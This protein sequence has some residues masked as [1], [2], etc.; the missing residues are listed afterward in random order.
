[1]P[2][3]LFVQDKVE[4]PEP[5]VI[6][7][8]VMEHDG[9]VEFA[10]TE[11]VTVPKNPFRGLIIIVDVPGTLTATETVEGFTEMVKSG[12]TVTW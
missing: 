3:T 4:F 12:G 8:G 10:M 1:M 2:A 9:L 5:P 11:S 6:L 7:V